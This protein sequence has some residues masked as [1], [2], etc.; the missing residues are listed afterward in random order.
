MKSVLALALPVCLTAV[1]IALSQRAAESAPAP[2]HAPTPAPASAPASQSVE[3]MPE[4]CIR[5]W[6]SVES[7][8]MKRWIKAVVLLPP[9]YQENPLRRYPVLYTLHGAGAPYQTYTE[10]STLRKA[11]RDRPMVVASFDGDRASGF[12]DSPTNPASQ[13]ETFFFK[14]FVPYVD[15]HYRLNGQ[16]A[17]TGFSMGGGG[18]FHYMIVKPD[19]FVSVSAQSMG[20]GRPGE[21][22]GPGRGPGAASRPAGPQ[23]GQGLTGGTMTR[24]ADGVAG[25]SRPDAPASRPDAPASRPAGGPTGRVNVVARIEE[26]VK[27]KVKLPP[28]MIHCGT[29]DGGMIA[30][31][32]TFSQF[33]A[34][35][36]KLIADEAANDPSLASETD[37]D[38]KA[39]ALGALVAARRLN[40][41]YLESPSGHNWPFWLSAGE[42][43]IDF[44]WRSFR[45]A[46]KPA[47]Q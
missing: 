31:S 5:E 7:P 25:P 14:E 45:D 18:A 24:P 12:V 20:F 26:Y 35:Q 3:N 43:V 15:S 44:H 29:E 23:V 27:D 40:F 41:V 33:L 10:M 47:G 13:F 9:G 38:K 21:G 36:N 37:P 42:L 30:R 1:L 17:V 2:T 22:F 8:T 16:R 11:L 6:F 39:K 32:R 4:G 28:M 19:F 34:E 46:P